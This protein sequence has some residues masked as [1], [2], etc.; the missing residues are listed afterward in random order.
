MLVVMR[1]LLRKPSSLPRPGTLIL[2]A[3][4]KLVSIGLLKNLRIVHIQDGTV[5]CE[6]SL[7][8]NMKY[9]VIYST[10]R[11][12]G[13]HTISSVSI[14]RMVVKNETFTAALKRYGIEMSQVNYLF[15]GWPKVEGET[16]EPTESVTYG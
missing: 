12:V 10:Y 8:V 13:S 9:T 16:N 1:Y 14:A 6:R 5:H 4:V 3:R 7:R 11:L 15:E 2:K